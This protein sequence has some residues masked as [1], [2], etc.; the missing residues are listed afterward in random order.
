MGKG[1]K[2]FPHFVF[3]SAFI[4]LKSATVHITPIKYAYNL[5]TVETWKQR[6]KRVLKTKAFLLFLQMVMR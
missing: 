3:Y 2:T 6:R 4:C 1:V 5:G